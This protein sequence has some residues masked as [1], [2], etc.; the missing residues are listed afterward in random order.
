MDELVNKNQLIQQT[1][2]KIVGGRTNAAT[3]VY[4]RVVG[5]IENQQEG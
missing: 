5:L 4:G 1:L 2:K 3:P